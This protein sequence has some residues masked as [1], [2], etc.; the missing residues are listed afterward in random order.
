MINLRKGNENKGNSKQTQGNTE[1]ILPVRP[2][3]QHKFFQ[4]LINETS[5]LLTGIRVQVCA[6]NFMIRSSNFMY[7]SQT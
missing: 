4:S 3:R 1:R 2:C 7:I 6:W 5:L